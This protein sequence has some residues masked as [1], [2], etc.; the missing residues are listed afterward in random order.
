MQAQAQQCNYL[1]HTRNAQRTLKKMPG[2]AL[3]GGLQRCESA[4]AWKTFLIGSCNVSSCI[5]GSVLRLPGL[6][7]PTPAASENGLMGWEK[8][9]LAASRLDNGFLLTSSGKGIGLGSSGSSSSLEHIARS[10][11]SAFMRACSSSS[12]AL[13]AR[14][15][16]AGGAARAG[17]APKAEGPDP[18]PRIPAEALGEPAGRVEVLLRKAGERW[19][20]PS[21]P[22][23]LTMTSESWEAEDF[24]P[25]QHANQLQKPFRL[26]LSTGGTVGG[27]WPSSEGTGSMIR[28]VPTLMGK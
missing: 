2:T 9:L 4:H 13:P 21:P 7:E 17:P 15:P 11:A 14:P 27:A 1:P 28:T 12:A 25:E 24:S 5:L 10:S 18:A 26:E 3:G 6:M 20:T 22:P 16:G 23:G 8:C 19:P